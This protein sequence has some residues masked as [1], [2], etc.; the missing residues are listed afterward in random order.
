[1]VLDRSPSSRAY[2]IFI[3]FSLPE[4]ISSDLFGVVAQVRGLQNVPARFFAT[5]QKAEREYR[6]NLPLGSGQNNNFIRRLGWCLVHD[7]HVFLL[8]LGW[9]ENFFLILRTTFNS[10]FNGVEW[11]IAPE[12]RLRSSIN[13]LTGFPRQPMQFS[14]LLVVVIIFVVCVNYGETLFALNVTFTREAYQ[15]VWSQE[16]TIFPVIVARILCVYCV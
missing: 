3:Y 11:I 14:M 9:Q 16:A 13:F 10:S 5:N 2:F 4:E 15:L 6:I 7:C 8:F 1:M 12:P